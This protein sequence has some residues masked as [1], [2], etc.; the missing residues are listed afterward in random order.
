MGHTLHRK[1]TELLLAR[2]RSGDWPVGK[3]LPAEV[4]LAA[5]LGVSRTTLRVGLADLEKL[6]LVVR[7]KRLGTTV[8]AANPRNLLQQVTGGV[9]Q[10]L[11]IAGTSV[12][13]ILSLEDV[14]GED[15][16]VLDGLTSE[17]GFWLCVT[18]T[19]RIVGQDKPFNWTQVY[20]VDRYAGIRPIL[21][22]APHAV[23]KAVE[24]AFGVSVARIAQ[25]VNARTCPPEA[26]DYLGLRETDPVLNIC[27]R[28]YDAKD[29]LIEV[30]DAYY[31]PEK[32][33]VATDVRI[34]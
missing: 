6:G 25:T 11:D 30:S 32:F 26:A 31:D 1:V 23:Y 17:T 33:A 4:D 18:G 5:E 34:A 21:G 16:Q 19:R 2:I 9:E 22:S 28:L 15:I 13:D 10:L 12:L 27:A 29:R 7:R 14:R 24:E 3:R 8:T 20:V